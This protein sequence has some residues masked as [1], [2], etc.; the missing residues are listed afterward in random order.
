MSLLEIS[1]M[2]R[3]DKIFSHPGSVLDL[4]DFDMDPDPDPWIRFVE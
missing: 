3:N 2:C 4:F 1:L